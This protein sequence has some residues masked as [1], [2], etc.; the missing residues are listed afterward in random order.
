MPQGDWSFV[1]TSLTTFAVPVAAAGVGVG[2]G[3]AGLGLTAVGL[4]GFFAAECDGV[5]VGTLDGAPPE[6]PPSSSPATAADTTAATA[7]SARRARA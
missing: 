1:A 3:G 2:L 6:H 7:G 5:P 4:A